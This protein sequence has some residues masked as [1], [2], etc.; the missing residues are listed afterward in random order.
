MNA[1]TLQPVVPKPEQVHRRLE[2]ILKRGSLNVGGNAMMDRLML[3]MTRS[4]DL[5]CSYCFVDLT[6]QAWGEDY[7]GYEGQGGYRHE[8]PLGDMSTETL[9]RSVDLLMRSSK[10]QL[11][12]QL[13][14]GE[15]ARRWEALVDM[16]RYATHHPERRERQL[17]LLFTTNGINLSA[18]RLAELQGLPVILQ[19]SLDGDERG[20]RFRRGHLLPQDQAVDRMMAAVEALK[21]SGLRWFMNATMPPAAAGDVMA[22]YRWA[23][24]VGVPALQMNYATGMMWSEDQMAEYLLGVQEMLLDHHARPEGLDLFNWRND[25]DPVPLCGDVI[26]DVD[27]TLFQVGA[28]FHERRFPLLRKAYRRAHLDDELPFTGMRMRLTT[29]LERTRVALA[30][31]PKDMATFEQNIHLGAAVDLVVQL[32]KRRLGLAD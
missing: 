19:F 26:V 3:M 18:E 22:R 20:S 30:D 9:H 27:G 31:H 28:L 8:L 6:E 23:R 5:R 1:P 7:F 25:A 16:F 10:P 12:I 29:L 32:T 15:P 13:F 17:E 24:E 21:A 14:G 4:C 11:G 2:Q